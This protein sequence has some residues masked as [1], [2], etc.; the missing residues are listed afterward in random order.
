[1]TLEAAAVEALFD[2]TYDRLSESYKKQS[3]DDNVY[4][5]GR[6]G[7]HN[8]VLCLIPRMGKGNAASVALA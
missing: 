5:N 6:I 8:V 7:N 3:G 4:Y 2:E 1:L